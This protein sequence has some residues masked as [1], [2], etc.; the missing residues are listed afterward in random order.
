M[1]EDWK[2]IAGWEGLYAVSSNGRIKSYD[3][4]VT[5]LNGKTRTHKGRLVTLKK[6]GCYHGVSLFLHGVGQRYY[7]H[8]LVA[9]AFIP[10]PDGRPEVNHKDGNKF[11]NCVLNLEWATRSENAKHA[12][13]MGLTDPPPARKGESQHSAKLTEHD[14]NQIRKTFKPGMGRLLAQKYGV[15]PPSI[16]GVINGR[17]WKHVA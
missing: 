9:E 6:T 7:A 5:E 8:R 2:D 14:V 12:F 11:N 13:A 17:T 1:I 4:L 3:R 10:N 16:Y 15:T